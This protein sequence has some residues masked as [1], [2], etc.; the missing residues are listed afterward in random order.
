MRRAGE[1]RLVALLRELVEIESPSGSP[2]AQAVSARIAEELEALGAEAKVLD[3]GHLRADLAGPGEPLL[4]SGHVDTVWPEGTLE[5]MPFRVEGSRAFG[6]GVYDM[7]ACLVVLVDAIRRAGERRRALRVFLTAD[8]EKGSVSGRE[9][10]EEAARGVA[11]GF[12]VEPPSPEG[13]L[14]TARKGLGRFTLAIKG[15]A[16][17]AGT[18]PDEGVSAIEE[19]AHQIQALHALNDAER[20]CTVNVGVVEGGTSTNVIPP[21]ALARIDVRVSYGE[22]CERIE[23]ALAE[24]RPVNPKAE[25]ELGGGWTRPPLERSEGV[26]LLF[27]RAREAGRELGLVLQEITSGGGSDGN[28]IGAL[29]VPVLDGLG[30]RGSGAHS[31]DE[32]VELDSIPVRAELLAKLLQDPGL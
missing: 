29:G 18:H 14:K 7:K 1:T 21:D 28:L 9:P 25:L 30:A 12:V 26:A 11:A 13:H 17:H 19:L 27:A 32:R 10:L 2:G 20:G 5:T 3:G 6:P 15:R 31:P 23:Q 16:A 24:L 22:D 8:E 4:L